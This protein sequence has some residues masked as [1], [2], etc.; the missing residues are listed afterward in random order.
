[1]PVRRNGPRIFEAVAASSLDPHVRCCGAHRQKLIG[2]TFI[3][4][5]RSIYHVN[6]AMTEGVFGITDKLFNIPK[7]IYL[8]IK[9][10]M[11]V[12]L[13]THAINNYIKALPAQKSFQYRRIA[14]V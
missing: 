11:K 6:I 14:V 13:H 9:P 3:G 4:Q 8:V 12:I 1:M 7:F 2:A 5:V 10:V